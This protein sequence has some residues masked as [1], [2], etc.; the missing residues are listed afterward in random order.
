MFNPLTYGENHHR[1]N[2]PVHAEEHSISKLQVNRSNKKIKVSLLVVRL[3]GR[4]KFNSSKP[5]VNCINHMNQCCEKKGYK[6]TTIYYTDSDGEIVK[7][8]LNKLNLDPC[9]HVTDYY[10]KIQHLCDE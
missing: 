2:K 3:S 10:R 6:I 1:N 8:S 4:D 7:T 5:C 9:K